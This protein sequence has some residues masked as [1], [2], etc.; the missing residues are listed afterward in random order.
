MFST[1]SYTGDRPF[2][3]K[4]IERMIKRELPANI[5]RCKGF[6][7]L[8]DDP[9]TRYVLQV[10]GRRVELVAERAWGTGTPQNRIVAIAHRSTLNPDHLNELFD[11]CASKAETKGAGEAE[12]RVIAR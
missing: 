5:Y 3:R 4:A 8:A 2:A 12:A 10:V 11:A 6:V 7:F 9:T 1:W